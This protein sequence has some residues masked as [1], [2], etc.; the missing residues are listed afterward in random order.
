MTR[1][2]EKLFVLEDVCTISGALYDRTLM[3]WETNVRR[4]WHA[5]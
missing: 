1:A 2:A 3:A 5:V 4:A